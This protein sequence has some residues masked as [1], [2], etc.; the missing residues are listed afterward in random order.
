MELSAARLAI[1]RAVTLTC[2]AGWT[3]QRDGDV[4]HHVLWCVHDGRGM[5][6]LDGVSVPLHAGRVLLLKPTAALS[7]S[8]DDT[9]PLRVTAIH[10]D[11][12]NARGQRVRAPE[13]PPAS[14]TITSV[15][16]FESVCRRISRLDG[17]P[18]GRAEAAAYLLAMLVGLRAEPRAETRARSRTVALLDLAARAREQIGTVRGV[19]DLADEAGYGVD[20]FT[21]L[22]KRATGQTP[23]DFLI[24]ARLRHARHLLRHSDLTIGQIAASA[25]YR[26]A[27][28]FARQFKQ[29]VGQTPGAYRSR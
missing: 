8:Q 17:L 14:K 11:V 15:E 9:A 26:D 19:S 29:R 10:F 21:V 28:F 25:G 27:P 13:L 7:A 2:P 22:F 3:W 4:A 18:G 20:H 23:G 6:T 24:D 5:M 1:S 12:L 16:L